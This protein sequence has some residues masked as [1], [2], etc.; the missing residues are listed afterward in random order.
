MNAA[1]TERIFRFAAS[2]LGWISVALFGVP[3]L[4]ASEQV[5]A[6]SRAWD[7]DLKAPGTYSVQSST[8]SMGS[9]QGVRRQPIQLL[10]V[11]RLNH[12]R[13]S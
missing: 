2:R 9:P 5:A 1:W 3:V 12:T 11:T 8:T 7:F 6:P 4:W 10:S 13:T